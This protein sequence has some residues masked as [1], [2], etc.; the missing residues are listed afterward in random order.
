MYKVKQVKMSVKVAEKHLKS[1]TVSFMCC[2]FA[3]KINQLQ[4]CIYKFKRIQR[5]CHTELESNKA[6]ETTYSHSRNFVFSAEY[7]QAITKL[8]KGIRWKTLQFTM[9]RPTQH[10]M[11]I[12]C[13]NAVQTLF[14]DIWNFQ[15]YRNI[16]A[17]S[18]ES[19]RWKVSISDDSMW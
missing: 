19:L 2:F 6:F 8:V 5:V 7:T 4:Q 16:Y 14:N 10:Q 3:G 11:T 15:F 13:I 18:L 1:V 9:L 17:L 12:V